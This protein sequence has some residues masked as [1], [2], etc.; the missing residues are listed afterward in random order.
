M[1]SLF[2]SPRYYD[3]I[4]Q[5]INLDLTGLGWID[6]VYPLAMMGE[7]EEGTF[8]E[9]Y[10]NDGSR[11][12]IRAF[13]SGNSISFFTIEDQD[14]E[15]ESDYFDCPLSL[16]VWADLTKVDGTKEYNYTNELVIEVYDV[17]TS[18]G[19]YNISI[20][21]QGVFDGFTQLEKLENQNVMLPYTAFK[22]SFSAD[23]LICLS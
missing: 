3:K 10:S 2:D 21:Y 23:V 12:N 11:E 18:H 15:D 6:T 22:I 9:V 20:D 14:Q 8:P 7:D 5:E 19:A 17:L 4:I 16:I 13:P 1:I